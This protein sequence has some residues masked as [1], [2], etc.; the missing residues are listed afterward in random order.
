MENRIIKC[1]ETGI[2]GSITFLP[3]MRKFLQ[4]MSIIF[5]FVC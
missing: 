3:K 4:L 2:F 1:A 5:M